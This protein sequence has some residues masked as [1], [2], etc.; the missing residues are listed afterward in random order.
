VQRQHAKEICYGIIYGMGA[1]SLSEQLGVSEED[2][3]AY[4]E[5]FKDKYVGVKRYIRTC[6][7]TTSSTGMPDFSLKLSSVFLISYKTFFEVLKFETSKN[8]LIFAPETVP[9]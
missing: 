1:K 8:L 9:D 3:F 4:M 6:V 7:E 5:Q 2:A